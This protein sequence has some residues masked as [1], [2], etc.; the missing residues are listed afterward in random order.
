[1]KYKELNNLVITIQNISG[2]QETKIQ[3]KLFK[4]YEKVKTIYEDYLDKVEE[5]RLDNALTDEKGA[6]ILNEQGKYKF[7]KDGLKKLNKDIIILEDKEFAFEKIPVVNPQGLEE[8][9]FLKDWLSG[10]EFKEEE[11]EEL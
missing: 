3:K 4:V 10:V 11:T 6:L 2:A 7:S 5:L 1:M 8:F 9:I